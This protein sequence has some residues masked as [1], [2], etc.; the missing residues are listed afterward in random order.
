LL[1]A[2]A[3]SERRRLGAFL[4]GFLLFAAPWTARNVLRFGSW[5]PFAAN[6]GD[7]FA[8]HTASM[9]PL[10]APG[11]ERLA[12]AH[13]A[14][15]TAETEAERS[16]LGFWAGFE[17]LSFLWRAGVRTA[18]S[19]HAGAFLDAF[20]VDRQMVYWSA[21]PG[22]V[23]LE[24]LSSAFYWTLCLFALG[25]VWKRRPRMDFL[26]WHF[27]ATLAAYTLAGGIDRY[28]FPVL[29]YL[30]LLAGLAF[31]GTERYS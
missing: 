15:R 31:A 4:A 18:L 14:W 8:R 10:D 6:V 23:R 1:A 22:R 29:P 26:A 27:L 3:L 17:N 25:A 20:G 21:G 30:S 24:R 19:G 12:P 16:R 9:I 11:R 13:R 5:T 2:A 28:H 7:T